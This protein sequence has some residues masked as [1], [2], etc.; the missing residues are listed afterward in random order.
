MSVTAYISISACDQRK[1]LSTTWT[2]ETQGKDKVSGLRLRGIFETQGTHL[3]SERLDDIVFDAHEWKRADVVHQVER[4]S[5]DHEVYA[6]K[7]TV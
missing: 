3:M 5:R 7:F 2:T 1:L 4:F 6:E